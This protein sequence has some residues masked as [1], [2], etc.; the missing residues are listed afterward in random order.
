MSVEKRPPLRRNLGPL[1]GFAVLILLF[2]VIAA[3]LVR[4]TTAFWVL[5]FLGLV[6][7]AGFVVLNLKDVTAFFISRQAR[8][9]ANVTISLIGVAGIAVCVNV[10][11]SQRFD[12]ATDWTA[13][14]LYTLSDQTKSILRSLDREVKVLAFFSNNSEN[15]QSQQQRE[16]AK[17]ILGRYGRESDKLM[18]KFVDPA[19]DPQT[20]SIYEI[21][22]DGTVVFESGAKIEQVSTMDEQKLT[23]AIMKVVRDEVK[24]IYF[25]TGHEERSIDVFDA[26]GYNRAKEALERQNYAV[27]VLA[28]TTQADLPADCSALVILAPKTALIPHEAEVISK[29]LDRNGKLLLMLDPS[30]GSVGDSNQRLIDLMERWGVTVG[31][32]YAVVLDRRFFYFLVGPSAPVV[33]DFEF[34]QL[35][36]FVQ[37]AIF[38]VA[39]SV[40][41]S[42]VDR[43]N[44]SVKSLAKTI[45]VIGVSWG[46]TGRGED[47]IFELEPEYTEGIDTPPPVSLAVAVE[48]K[49]VHSGLEAGLSLEEPSKAP[50]RIVVFGDSDFASNAFFANSG[51]GDLFLNA[52]HWLTLEADLIGIA[53]TDPKQR[54]LRRMTGNEAVLVQM[55]AMFCIPLAVFLVGVFVWWRRRHRS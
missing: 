22:F 37:P 27:E 7:L 2:G 45:D 53:V 19:V 6:A 10:I 12:K 54:S 28:L 35:T 40:T 26:A 16:R 23:S 34:H 15:S 9:G 21:Q 33:M 43:A 25:L 48:R 38:Q 29:Y 36:R 32:D 5:L 14:K 31:N 55:A 1:L 39:R 47:G 49:G 24:K 52:V 11:V 20:S 18:V 51:G 42:E 4:A 46:E 44:V 13:E 3:V 30:I 50:T 41:P 8:Y 17:D